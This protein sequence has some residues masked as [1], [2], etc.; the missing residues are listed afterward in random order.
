MSTVVGTAGHIDH[1]KSTLVRALTGIDPDRLKEEKE[2]GITIDIG[3]AHAEIDGANIAFVDVPGHERFVKNMLAGVGGIDAVLLVVAADESVM[4]QT[5]EHFD[6]CRLLRIPTGIIAITKSDLVDADTLELTTLETRELVAGTFLEGTPI[7]PVSAATGAGLDTLRAALAA[8]PKRSRADRGFVRM[9]IDRVFSVKGFGTVVT[10]TLVSGEL[11][12]DADLV[13]APAGLPVK[14][15]GLQVHGGTLPRVAAGNRVAANLGGVDV[16]QISR[17]ETLLV[18]GLLEPTRRVDA[19]I[20][21]LASATTIKHGARVRFHQGTAEILGRIS[22][23]SDTDVR[24]RLEEPAI[25]ARGDR[26]ILRAYSPPTTI[27]GGEVLDPHPPRAGVRTEAARTRFRLLASDAPPERV[28]GALIEE[29]GPAGLRARALVERAGVP[30]VEIQGLVSRLQQSREVVDLGEVLVS[31]SVLDSLAARTI[32]D[33]GAHHAAQPLSAGMPREELRSRQ[34]A[35][36]HD[37]V[38]AAVLE[39]LSSEGRIVA[40]D[41]VALSTHRIELSPDEQRAREALA[42]LFATAAL[43]PPLPSEVAQ[44]ARIETRTADRILQLLVRERVLVKVDDLLFHRE[45]LER[46]KADVVALKRGTQPAR[47]DV[48]SFKE[49]YGITRK[50]AIPLLEYLDRERVTRRQGDSRVVL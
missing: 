22:L 26:F 13:V 32:T 42:N 37:A 35:H 5:R 29:A 44:A 46:L 21:R 8:L 6:I 12:A 39:R 1:G 28:A 36:A 11:Q 9:P 30:L 23:A 47:V 33:L 45:A 40:R 2:R 38:F 15:R 43:R 31:R 19:V 14:I 16:D 10:G 24:I 20:E 41:R 27:A 4:P 50:F 25:L 17:G 3:F 49:K 48:A 18:G 7:V 34:F